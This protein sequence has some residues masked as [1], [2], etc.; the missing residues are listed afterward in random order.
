MA[1]LQ[2][3]LIGG[4]GTGKTFIAKQLSIRLGVPALDLDSIFWVQGTLTYQ[5]RTPDAERDSHLQAFLRHESGSSRE[6][7][8]AG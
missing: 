2:L 7:I 6:S 5:A 4:G 1:P 3:C 8:T